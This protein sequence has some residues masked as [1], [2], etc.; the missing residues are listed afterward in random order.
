MEFEIRD[1]PNFQ[2]NKLIED[3]KNY[4]SKLEKEMKFYD[5][6]CFIEL[7][8]QN[9][10]PPLN[11]QENLEIISLCLNNIKNNSIE[12]VSFGTEAGIFNK[13][14]FQ[15]VV[16]GPGSIKQAHKPDEFIELIQL[17]KCENFLKKI[18]KSL[19]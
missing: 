12:T 7:Q 5:K 2:T 11:T 3:I 19:Y 6:R 9:D 17:K 4:L 1:I 16:C 18:I 15:T 13:L 14:G 10:F 8:E